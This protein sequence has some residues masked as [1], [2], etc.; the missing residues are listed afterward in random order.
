MS[1]GRR[2][3]RAPPIAHHPNPSKKNNLPFEYPFPTPVGSEDFSS[4]SRLLNHH[5]LLPSST[6]ISISS[7]SSSS[8]FRCKYGLSTTGLNM[9]PVVR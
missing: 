7:K 1:R 6:R 5:R 9:Y 8:S 2:D 4:R 3:A